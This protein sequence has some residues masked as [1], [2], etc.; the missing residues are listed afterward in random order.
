[1][2]YIWI[3]FGWVYGD[4]TGAI[5]DCYRYVSRLCESETKKSE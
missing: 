1:M 3:H 5:V 2:K 4:G